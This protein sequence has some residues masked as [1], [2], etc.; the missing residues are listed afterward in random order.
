[1]VLKI[2]DFSVSCSA[3]EQIHKMLGESTIRT[4]DPLWPNKNTI[5]QS[6]M[7]N[8]Q[9]GGIGQKTLIAAL[10]QTGHWSPGGE[11]LQCVSLVFLGFYF[12]L[13]P[14]HHRN[15][16]H[17]CYFTLFNLLNC[18]Y[19]LMLLWMFYLFLI[20][21]PIPHAPWVGESKTAAAEYLVVH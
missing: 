16:C 1:M 13:S 19:A 11:K 15:Y 14:S 4:A 12:S 6:V 5:P 8:I 21:F 3:C 10:G 7:P 18:S 9:T 17:Y 20:L 2:K